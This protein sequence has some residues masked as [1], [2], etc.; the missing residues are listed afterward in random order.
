M[1]EGLE[2]RSLNKGFAQ[3]S[4]LPQYCQFTNEWEKNLGNDKVEQMVS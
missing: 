2:K 1:Q 4:A 3:Q